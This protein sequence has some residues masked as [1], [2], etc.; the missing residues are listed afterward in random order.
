MEGIEYIIKQI[1]YGLEQAGVTDSR[2]RAS[3]EASVWHD[4]NESVQSGFMTEQEAQD[5]F[6]EW[7]NTYLGLI[8][9]PPA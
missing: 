4:L 1:D 6:C 5:K 9:L 2:T 8:A 7:R 3:V